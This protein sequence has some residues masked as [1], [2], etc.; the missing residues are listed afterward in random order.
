MIFTFLQIT[1]RKVN[2]LLLVNDLC[3]IWYLAFYRV[4]Q[5]AECVFWRQRIKNQELI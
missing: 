1:E 4:F 5:Q 3:F 2:K